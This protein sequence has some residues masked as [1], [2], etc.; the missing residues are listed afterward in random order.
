M[1]QKTLASF[2]TQQSHRSATGVGVLLFLV[3]AVT[4]FGQLQ[5]SLNEI[6]GVQEAPERK[7]SGP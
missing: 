7:A 3:G 1:I 4:V 5:H 2:Q 6:W